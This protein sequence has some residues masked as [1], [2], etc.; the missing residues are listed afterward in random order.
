M[1]FDLMPHQV[2][3]IQHALQA[4]HASIRLCR[5]HTITYKMTGAAE[6]ACDFTCGQIDEVIAIFTHPPKSELQPTSSAT[7][8]PNCVT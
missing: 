4:M 5:E 6:H 1:N 7:G 8:Y 3:L 2:L